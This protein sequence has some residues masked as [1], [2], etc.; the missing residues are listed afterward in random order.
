MVALYVMHGKVHLFCGNFKNENEAIRWYYKNKRNLLDSD[1]L[2]GDPVTVTI[3]NR[4]T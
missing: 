2:A 4:R 1:G 3:K